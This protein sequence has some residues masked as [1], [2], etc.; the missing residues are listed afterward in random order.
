[1]FVKSRKYFSNLLRHLQCAALLINS[2]SFRC[3]RSLSSNVLALFVLCYVSSRGNH[4]QIQQVPSRLS[5]KCHPTALGYHP[6]KGG[7]ILCLA[8]GI[9]MVY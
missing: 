1:M 7:C 6:H 3:V 4:K 5:V 2:L 9:K 8:L